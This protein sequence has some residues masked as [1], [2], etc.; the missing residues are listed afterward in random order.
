LILSDHRSRVSSCISAP[1]TLSLD[2]AARLRPDLVA[3]GLAFSTP[4]PGWTPTPSRCSP[5]CGLGSRPRDRQ[6]IERSW[7]GLSSG[8]GLPLHLQRRA[9]ALDS[10]AASRTYGRASTR[11]WSLGAQPSHSHATLIA[12]PAKSIE[13]PHRMLTLGRV[14]EELNSSEGSLPLDLQRCTRARGCPRLH[15]RACRCTRADPGR[16]RPHSSAAPRSNA[17]IFVRN[18]WR[19]RLLETHSCRRSSRFTSARRLRRAVYDRPSLPKYTKP[20]PV[21][22]PRRRAPRSTR[23]MRHR[24]P[25]GGR[26]GVGRTVCAVS[27]LRMHRAADVAPRV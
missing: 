14:V 10:I 5:A 20:D 25:V 17:V 27:R 23:S 24:R 4:L 9:R 16:P 11:A 19:P 13:P 22:Q 15:R 2:R 12:C 1:P 8:E 7:A 6:P 21:D 3:S 26:R 18:P